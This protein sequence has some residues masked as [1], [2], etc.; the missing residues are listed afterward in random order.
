MIDSRLRIEKNH[1]LGRLGRRYRQIF[2]ISIVNLKSKEST[3]IH[4]YRKSIVHNY[5]VY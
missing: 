1:I 3:N 2:F 5:Y 4:R